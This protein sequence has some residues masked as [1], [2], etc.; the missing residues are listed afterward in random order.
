MHYLTAWRLHDL[1]VPV[2]GLLEGMGRF[3]PAVDQYHSGRRLGRDP[4]KQPG[5]VGMDPEPV[6]L[7]LARERDLLK[8]A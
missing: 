2:Q 6:A 3:A 1:S 7:E 5:T 4:A 8:F